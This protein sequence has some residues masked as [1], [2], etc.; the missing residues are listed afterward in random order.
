MQTPRALV[1]AA[2]AVLLALVL[3]V[4]VNPL[5]NNDIWLHLTTG[6]LIL[7]RGAVPRVDE[8]SFTRAGAPYIAHEWLA[9]ILFWEVFRAAGTTGLI[10]LKPAA[11]AAVATLVA[12]ASR[13]LGAGPAATF[14]AAALAVASMA[15]H[16]FVRPHLLTFV[17]LAAA[18]LMLVHLRDGSRRAL[19]ALLALQVLWANLHG[20]FILGF[21]LAF[22]MGA[23]V[24]GIGMALVS[25]LNP[26]GAGLFRFVLTFT[27]PIFRRRIR[28]WS[29]P[30]D[31]PFAGSLHFW[32]YVVVL[33]A[34]AGAALHHA[35]RR[36]GGAAA[37][38]IAFGLLSLASKRNAS[39]LGVAAAPWL[40]WAATE[41]FGPR[42]GRARWLAGA[43]GLG[44]SCVAVAALAGATALHGVPHETGRTRRAGLGVGE[45]VP[46]A[47]LDYIKS[48]GIA[49]DALDSMGF[50]SYLIWRVWPA[51]RVF[52]D[53]RLDVYGGPFI[54]RYSLAMADPALMRDLIGRQRLDYALISY[55]LE[56]ASGAVGALSSD[57]GWALVHF[58]DL[59]MVYLKR[60]PR[61]DELIARDA[62]R[63][64][65][66]YRFLSGEMDFGG[67]PARGL[68]EASRALSEV[69]S[70]LVARL[71]A[72]TAL[73]ALGRH[74]E[75]V[76]ILEEASARLDPE[77][78]GRELLFG[79]LGISYMEL[80]D[81]E[82]AS[83]AMRKLLEISPEST[84]A[85]RML[86]EIEA[87]RGWAD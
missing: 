67:D 9:Q 86:E 16:L 48:R 36:R 24:A 11:L 49:G 84:Y 59:A 58:D 72:G 28:E 18:T 47:A 50:G 46:V 69:P 43:R 15:S 75:A 62:Y 20:G 27:D 65:N 7:E 12:L 87:R 83:R 71:M 81:D 23:W 57:P 32:I 13:K 2:G 53:S 5:T 26:Q 41:A 31:E 37:T 34:C 6:R 54:E 68:A 44:L 76:S 63:V 70:S 85:R 21:G 77:A 66:P 30:F 29:S 38:L 74:R 40:A 55:Q 61:W 39:L 78:G 60:A 10:L 4:G 45:N 33:I 64:V 79:L 42:V 56:E 73:Q 14:W 19:P 35:R 51:S 17:M 25:L 82:R 52:I 1:W 80:G 8:Y 22:L 3:A